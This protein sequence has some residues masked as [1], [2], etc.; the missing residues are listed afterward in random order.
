MFALGGA[1]VLAQPD[2]PRGLDPRSWK[3]VVL[4][5]NSVICHTTPCNYI[6][7]IYCECIFPL[8]IMADIAHE[9]LRREA[10]VSP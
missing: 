5:G 10:D 4:S 6:F 7:I 9:E 8:V 2:R 3:D 1:L